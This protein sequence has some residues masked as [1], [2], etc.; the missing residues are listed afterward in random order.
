MQLV[1]QGCY[2]RCQVS[3]GLWRIGPVLKHCEVPKHY[4][5]DC[6]NFSLTLIPPWYFDLAFAPWGVKLRLRFE[7]FK[8]LRKVLGCHV[9]CF[10][11]VITF[12]YVDQLG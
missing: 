4:D 3:F 5:Q 12:Q 6:S 1:Y 7:S 11:G 10:D 9:V 8:N 2:T